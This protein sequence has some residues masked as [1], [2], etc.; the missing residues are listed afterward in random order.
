MLLLESLPV[1]ALLLLLLGHLRLQLCLL[2]ND[3]LCFLL[4]N[5]RLVL[6]SLLF[7]LLGA[8]LGLLLLHVGQVPL[9]DRGRGR[10]L[11]LL[12][13]LAVHEAELLAEQGRALCHLLLLLRLEGTL[14]LLLLDLC[15]PRVPLPLALSL[16]LVLLLLH[17]G[18]LFGYEPPLFLLKR[19]SLLVQFP[20]HLHAL[21]DSLD[22][23]ALLLATFFWIRLHFWSFFA[24]FFG[25][26]CGGFT[27]VSSLGSC[28]FTVP[29]QSLT[30]AGALLGLLLVLLPPV[31]QR[32]GVHALLVLVRG[33]GLAAAAGEVLQEPVHGVEDAEVH[34]GALATLPGLPKALV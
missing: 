21:A 30:T 3:R 9:R 16:E 15:K 25:S 4:I 27:V 23:S 31:R 33:L 29:P 26:F 8:P 6:W 24:G 1:I 5:F 32:L 13:L 34:L 11:A 22:C 10:L 12:R 20:L 7:I 2:L 28:R 19:T 17:A 18:L 14:V